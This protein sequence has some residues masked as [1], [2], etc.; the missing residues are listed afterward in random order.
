M[1]VDSIHDID[2]YKE[3]GELCS[4]RKILCFNYGAWGVWRRVTLANQ[5]NQSSSI[6]D[7]FWNSTERGS[8]YDRSFSALV[9]ISLSSAIFSLFIDNDLDSLVTCTRN[10]TGKP[11]IIPVWSLIVLACKGENPSSGSCSCNK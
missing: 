4:I 3:T 5:L 8:R 11:P 2:C 6:T 1:H 9:F 10:F 7:L